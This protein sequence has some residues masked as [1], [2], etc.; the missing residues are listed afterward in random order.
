MNI[1]PDLNTVYT[2][3]ETSKTLREWIY[4]A[5]IPTNITA[6]TI[7]VVAIL[8]TVISKLNDVNHYNCTG[9]SEV[10]VEFIKTLTGVDLNA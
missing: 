3:A 8:Y 10:E 2:V 6:T 9:F 7:G 4:S 1:F 5:P